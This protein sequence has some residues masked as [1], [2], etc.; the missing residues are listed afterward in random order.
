MTC[1]SGHSEHICTLQL[2]GATLF[3]SCCS[4]WHDFGT[5]VQAVLPSLILLLHFMSR[6]NS[7]VP[8]DQ[9]VLSLHSPEL[10]VQHITDPEHVLHCCGYACWSCFTLALLV[11]AWH[12]AAAPYAPCY[13]TESFH[14]EVIYSINLLS[15]LHVVHLSFLTLLK[16]TLPVA[17]HAEA[18]SAG[19]ARDTPP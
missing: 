19:Q 5:S 15:L 4:A 16:G 14:S 8:Q 7:A 3:H 18:A 13:S 1:T 2:P 17:D 6:L 9:A 12:H 11:Y 10:P